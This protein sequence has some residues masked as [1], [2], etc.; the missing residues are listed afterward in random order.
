MDS[1]LRSEL[2]KLWDK[3][4]EMNNRQSAMDTR[5][6]IADESRATSARQMTTMG[7]DIRQI[8]QTLSEIAVSIASA[9]VGIRMAHAIG[10]AAAGFVGWLAQ[11]LHLA[12]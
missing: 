7:T 3:L 11:F 8:N 1:D 2:D 12:K 9:R 5:M 6:G 4:E 10:L